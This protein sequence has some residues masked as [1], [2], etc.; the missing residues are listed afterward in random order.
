MNVDLK[1]EVSLFSDT[2]HFLRVESG[3]HLAS[4]TQ[5]SL[6]GENMTS[7]LNEQLSHCEFD[8]QVTVHRDKF[9]YKTN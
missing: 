9:L 3:R 7:K 5:Q 4:T 8:V 2:Y 1:T 6:E